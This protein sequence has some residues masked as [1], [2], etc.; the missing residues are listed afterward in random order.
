MASTYR[1]RFR[2][3][4]HAR[5]DRHQRRRPYGKGAFRYYGYFCVQTIAKSMKTTQFFKALLLTLCI[6]TAALAQQRTHVVQPQ[7]TLYR[8]AQRYSVTVTE[9]IR[10]NPGTDKG[11][12]IGQELKIPTSVAPDNYHVVE[13][14]ETLHSI[15]RQYNISVDALLEHNSSISRT[16]LPVGIVIV[17]PTKSSR[18]TTATAPD[19][20]KQRATTEGTTGLKLYT[21]PAGQTIYNLCRLTGWGESELM[22]Y[23]P[24]LKDGLRV[25]MNILIPDDSLPQNLATKAAPQNENSKQIEERPIPTMPPLTVV[26]ALPFKEDKQRRFADYYEGFLLA[27][28][29]TKEQGNSVTL[30]V[31]DISKPLFDSSIEEIS[32]IKGIDFIIGGVSDE[33]VEALAQIASSQECNYVIPFNSKEHRF[34]PHNKARILQVNTPHEVLHKMTAERFIEYYPNHHVLFINDSSADSQKDAF[35]TTLKDHLSRSK[36]YFDEIN[37]NGSVDTYLLAGK[38]SSH[39]K[40]VCVPTSASLAAARGVLTSIASLRDSLA[41]TNI[42][43][44][45]HPEWQTYTR[46]GDL[47]A[48]CEGSF[49]TTF[50][51]NPKDV[52]HKEFQQEFVSWFGHGIGNTYPRYS[53]LGYDTARFFLM[54]KLLAHGILMGNEQFS[55]IQSYFWFTPDIIRPNLFHNSGVIFVRYNSDGTISRR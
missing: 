44:F 55:G 7:E 26:L 37:A 8:I 50:F 33:S 14:G 9:L 34:S 27:L 42:T 49:Y 41:I 32:K 30:H 40:V 3:I 51:S 20:K 16:K 24:T 5:I 18:A 17:I 15:A 52:A 6:A 35:I 25:G 46:L 23:N 38:A 22:H 36:I 47:I 48:Q 43:A 39:N 10:L 28:K 11:I 12:R 29:E 1:G 4:K 54:H 31:Y 19:P 21:V 13:K 2:E 53:I 45:G